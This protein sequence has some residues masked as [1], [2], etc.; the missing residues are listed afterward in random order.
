MQERVHQ[1]AG[2]HGGGAVKNQYRRDGLVNVG[3]R[4]R[5][6]LRGHKS[7]QTKAGKAQTIAVP[8]GGRGKPAREEEGEVEGDRGR[9]RGLAE[10]FAKLG[11]KSG[12]I[13]AATGNRANSAHESLAF[14]R[15]AQWR[16][17]EV[18]GNRSQIDRAKR[19][20]DRKHPSRSREYRLHRAFHVGIQA[21]NDSGLEE[22]M[23]SA[24]I[25]GVG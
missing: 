5:Q 14:G 17:A 6:L 9:A 20:P 1:Q 7:R 8:I 18:E 22:E 11:C 16:V 10:K 21:E 13:Q 19:E 25:A 4:D 3:G 2:V 15:R 23:Q 12:E 24:A